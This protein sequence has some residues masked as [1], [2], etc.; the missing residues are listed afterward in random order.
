M[1]KI[2]DLMTVESRCC[3]QV[4]S[5]DRAAAIMWDSDAGCVPVLSSATDRALV[6]MIT[7]RDLCMA[8][9][10]QGRTLREIPVQEAMSGPPARCHPD[11][12][13]AEALTTMSDAQVRRLPVV[14][15]EG[16][17]VGVLSL[18]DLLRAASRGAKTPESEDL[19]RAMARISARRGEE[20]PALPAPV[21]AGRKATKRKAAKGKTTRR[22]TTTRKK[23]SAKASSTKKT[24]KKVEPRASTKEVGKKVRRR[25][26]GSG[27]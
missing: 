20:I 17:V 3:T 6:G 26:A 2:R 27:G 15:E 7:D 1:M 5:L 24:G 9:Y 12:D 19:V 21:V 8:A 25:S 10:T 13:A 16:A 4:D 18:A 22:K 14:D 23:T 11:Q